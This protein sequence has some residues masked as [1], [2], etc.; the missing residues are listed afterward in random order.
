[1]V[2]KFDHSKFSSALLNKR[3]KGDITI[4]E[5]A[6]QSKVSS[7]GFQGLEANSSKINTATLVS[8]CNWMNIDPATFFTK[9][10]KPAGKKVAKK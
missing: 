8:L 5:A 1:M 3:E 7:S 10:G 2:Y 6:K 4:R 9:A